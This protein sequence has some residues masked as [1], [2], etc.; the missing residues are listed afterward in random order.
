MRKMKLDTFL[1]EFDPNHTPK[2]DKLAFQRFTMSAEKLKILSEKL[3][4]VRL[5]ELNLAISS[6]LTDN[7]SVLFTH[8][9][10]R[11]NTLV[12]N[13]CKLNANDLQS[14]A[15]ANVDGKLLELRHLDI[16]ENEV[17][18]NDLFTHSFPRLNTL[19]LGGIDLA[20]KGC[21]RKAR[22]VQSLARTNVEGKLPQFEHLDISHNDNLFAHLAQ[23]NQLKILCTS[24]E[25]ILNVEPDFLTSLEELR[26]SWKLGLK[27]NEISPITRCWSG[28]ENY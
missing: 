26:Y 16:S 25:S 13:G 28:F 2:L 6:G 21:S 17:E 27:E 9:F 5:T 10:P 20:L 18:I 22:D 12:L 14:L 3:S 7:L 11:L 15:Q 23:W 1:N 8:S 4:S 19:I 24:D